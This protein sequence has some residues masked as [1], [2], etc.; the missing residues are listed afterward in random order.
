MAITFPS[1]VEKLN[2][3]GKVDRPRGESASI[4]LIFVAF[5]NQVVGS[6][7]WRPSLTVKRRLSRHLRMPTQFL[8][9]MSS[10][11]LDEI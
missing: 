9:Y 10:D 11:E 8:T 5:L 2:I 6:H 1:L 7:S 4:L 3:L